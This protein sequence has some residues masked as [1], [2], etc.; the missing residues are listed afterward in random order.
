MNDEEDKKEQM[1]DASIL[2]KIKNGAKKSNK[3]KF[4]AVATR[5]ASVFSA[6]A[7]FIHTFWPLIL[8]VIVVTTI[9]AFIHKIIIEG[10]NSVAFVATNKVVEDNVALTTNSNGEAYFKINKDIVDKYLEEINKAYYEGYYESLHPDEQTNQEFV[11]DPENPYIKESEVYNW[12]QTKDYKPYLIKMIMAQIAS[13]YPKLGNYKGQDTGKLAPIDENGDYVAQGVVEIQ[14]TKVNR[15]G[16]LQSPVRLTYVSHDKLKEMISQDPPSVDTLNYFSFEEDTGLIYYA[17]YIEITDESGNTKSYYLKEES[18]SY[19]ALTAMC[20]MPYQFL[21][22]LLQESKNPNWVMAVI[23]LLL[24]DSDVVLMIQDQLNVD[25]YTCEKT[26]YNARKTEE[27]N[28]I[29]VRNS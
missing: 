23:D 3:S 5:L 19:T 27:V 8:I 18:A 21:F 20:N 28:M 10:N 14:R 4:K 13:T 16:S 6:I 9:S 11:Y 22:T 1:Q 12:F 25:K 29:S 7:S 24:E 17:T 2:N 15:D 26:S